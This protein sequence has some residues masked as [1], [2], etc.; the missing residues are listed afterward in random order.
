M[1]DYY[2][3]IGLAHGHYVFD[4]V[5]K[6]II[7]MYHF[8]FRETTKFL[9][10]A[11]IALYKPTHDN[12]MRFGFMDEKARD[13]C[14][15]CIAPLII[16]L[17]IKSQSQYSA[18]ISGYDSSPLHDLFSYCNSLSGLKNQLLTEQETYKKINEKDPK[19]VVLLKDK[20][21]LVYDAL[22][23][24]NYSEGAYAINI[25]DLSFER[26]MRNKLMKII[27]TFSSN[28]DYTVV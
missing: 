23:V 6:D 17:R 26:D 18:F 15:L 14:L 21:D 16:G 5:C 25:G 12:H 10:M 8:S 2:L 22:F 9:Q 27:N 13:F 1:K 3:N 19:T 28:A 24:N 20:L 4:G 11:F 7:E